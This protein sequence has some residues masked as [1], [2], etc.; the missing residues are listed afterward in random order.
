VDGRG[1]IL[2]RGRKYYLHRVQIGYDGA[3]HTVSYLMGTG[4]SFL[5]VKLHK[6]V[7]YA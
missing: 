6:D 2:G 4:E 5:G 3:G 7:S 1:S